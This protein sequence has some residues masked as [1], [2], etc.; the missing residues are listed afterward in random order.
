[1]KKTTMYNLII[2]RCYI[3]ILRRSLVN[4]L[5]ITP[6][7]LKFCDRRVY[8]FDIIYFYNLFPSGCSLL[9]DCC[10]LS[11]ILY[12]IMNHTMLRSHESDLV[13]LYILTLSIVKNIM[14]KLFC[15]SYIILYSLP[16]S[17][18]INIINHK[19]TI[20]VYYFKLYVYRRH[21][22]DTLIIYCCLRG[23]VVFC[24]I[25]RILYLFNEFSQ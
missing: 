10:L 15:Y 14:N 5:E 6:S 16:M 23:L 11:V 1:M 8:F 22:T 20:K 9:V 7:P 25:M 18:T 4:H 21:S 2:I 13:Q 12:N 24:A 17:Y 3:D 19:N